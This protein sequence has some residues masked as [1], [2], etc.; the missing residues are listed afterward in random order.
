MLHFSLVSARTKSSE[1]EGSSQTPCDS[2]ARTS[3]RL[4]ASHFSSFSSN[5][6]LCTELIPV[7]FPRKPPGLSCLQ[8]RPSAQ[9]PAHRP[10]LPQETTSQQEC[11]GQ[12]AAVISAPRRPEG[13]LGF[14]EASCAS[15]PSGSPQKRKIS[16]CLSLLPRRTRI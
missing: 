13:S 11:L 9:H 7:S 4:G 16:V 10:H 2:A 5:L 15:E 3:S 12:K 8:F 6:L 1:P 14:R